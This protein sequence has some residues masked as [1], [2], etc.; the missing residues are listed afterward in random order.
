MVTRH[1]C[2]WPS[3]ILERMYVFTGGVG[4]YCFVNKQ[5]KELRWYH[6]CLAF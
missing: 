5:L 6:A 4:G 3:W 2:F 1:F